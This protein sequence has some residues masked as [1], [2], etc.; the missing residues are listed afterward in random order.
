[1]TENLCYILH[2]EELYDLYSAPGVMRMIKSRRMRWMGLVVRM[3]DRTG[4]CRVLLVRP[5]GRYRL[6]TRRRW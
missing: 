3:G 2:N 6:K 4:A 1:M 5:E